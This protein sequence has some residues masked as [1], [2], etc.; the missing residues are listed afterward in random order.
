MMTSA[1]PTLIASQ[2]PGKPKPPGNLPD[3]SPE[4]P[5]PEKPSPIEEPPEPFHIPPPQ[6]EPPPMQAA[7]DAGRLRQSVTV[8]ACSRLAR[9][10][11]GS[12]AVAQK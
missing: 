4:L 3:R 12:A 6:H 11:R 7:A 1:R 5:D 8:A 2:Q 10:A 9:K